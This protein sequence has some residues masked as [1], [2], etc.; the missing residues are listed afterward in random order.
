MNVLVIGGGGREH[1]LAWA[2]AKSAKVNK[3]FVAPGNA[4]TAQENKCENVAID[5]LA[6][7]ELIA[8]AKSNNVSLTI[9]GPEAP[10]AEGIV[11]AF[12]NANLACFGPTQDAARLEASKA[13]CKEFMEKYAI[14]T[15]KHAS[16]SNTQ[17]ALDYLQ[18][19]SMP[20]V[21]KADGLAAGKGVIIAHDISE[22]EHA[23][24]TLLANDHDRIV[25]ED[26][27]SG[28]EASF[29]VVCDGERALP[30][31]SSQDHKARFD[32]DEGPNTGGMG[33][34]SPAPIVTPEL[35]TRVMK[36][37]I[38]PTLAGLKQEG[39]T[40]RG[41]LYAGL[42]ISDSNEPMVLEYNCRLGDPETQVLLP[43]LTS[44]FVDMIEAALAGELNSYRATW[45]E[46]VALGVVLVN[47]GYPGSYTKTDVIEGLAFDESNIKVFH[48]GTK[49]VN[50][51]IL[52]TGGRVLCVTALGESV[53]EAQA[54]AYDGVAK[55]TWPHCAYRK[56]IGY[57]AIDRKTH[58]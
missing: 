57:R 18:T 21:I 16:F 37:V 34:Y 49:L 51:D 26:F 6:I 10:L 56:D 27:L 40:Y 23:V 11:D 32:N 30:L 48:A 4:G 24:K 45:D 39:I 36:E 44:D 12:Y 52:A 41:F 43:R 28:E 19:Q 7:D 50:G 58:A 31:M 55:I 5:P 46:R 38:E 42:M 29:I 2:S 9:V 1:V 13:F 35:E 22:A 53:K 15:A 47:D 54:R 3:V 17:N 33:A 8:F 20:I 25:I 14:P